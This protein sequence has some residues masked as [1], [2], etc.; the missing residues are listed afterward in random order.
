M[1]DAEALFAVLRQ[2]VDGASVTAMERLVREGTDPALNRINALDFAA[3]NGLNEEQAIGAFLHA[4]GLGIFDLSWNVLCPGCG[5]VLGANATLKSVHHEEYHCPLC[6]AAYEP[7]P[8]E[9]IKLTFTPTPP[10]PHLA[11]PSPPRL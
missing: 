9:I 3:E 5:G 4:A 6:S 8:A 7:P 2:F 10:I 11:T 1:S